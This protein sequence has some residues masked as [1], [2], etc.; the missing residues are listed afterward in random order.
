M[1]K[2]NPI[3]SQLAA[4]TALRSD[5]KS[6]SAKA[7]L[8]R[9]MASKSNLVVAK[10]TSIINDSQQ[11]DFLPALATAF[12]RFFADGSD[13]GC[14]AKT[15]I[16]N[17]LYEF[18]HNEA[19]V[20]VRGIHHVQKEASFGPPV[21]VAAELRGLC[22]LGLARMGYP[23]V[24]PE[25]AELLV[26][27]EFQ[28]RVMAVRAVAY[29]GSE[30]GA[31]LLRMK[32]LAGD[33]E[34]EVIAECFIG[35]M[36]LS[37]KKSLPFVSRFL[38]STDPAMAESAALAIGG[39]RTPQAF[40]LLRAEW[41][42]HLQPQP[43]RPLLLGIAMTRQPAAVDFLLERIAE[44]RPAPAADAIAAMALYKH[45]EAIRAKVAAIVN[46]R[47]ENELLAAMKK[48]FAA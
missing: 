33:A 27:P 28:P 10:A 7:E 17:G 38:K 21:D 6:E 8:T 11:T 9:A 12:E 24:L 4:L 41:E 30:D 2:S 39:S 48:A 14:S 34:P 37:P 26:D 43:R 44:D 25:L 29:T 3:E 45:D 13:K 22:A 5:P 18:G 20:F 1:A 35:L 47:G 42:S 16:A 23:D 40:E 19:A 31:P 32:V 46:E 15:A 36:K